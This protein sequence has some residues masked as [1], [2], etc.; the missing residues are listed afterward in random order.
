MFLILKFKIL[1]AGKYFCILE[2]YII[3]LYLENAESLT[4]LKIN[5]SLGDELTT[6]I[7]NIIKQQASIPKDIPEIRVVSLTLLTLGCFGPV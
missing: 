2:Y 4:S 1:Y 6:R 5:F 3:I 7:N